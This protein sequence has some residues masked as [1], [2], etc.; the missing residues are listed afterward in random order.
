MFARVHKKSRTGACELDV[1]NVDEL[2]PLPPVTKLCGI[3]QHLDPVT[4]QCVDNVIDN[5]CPAGQHRDA[6]GKCVLDECP[7]GQER[8]PNTLQCVTVTGH[9]SDLGPGYYKDPVTGKCVRD[10]CPTGQERD[11]VTDLC[12]LKK[13]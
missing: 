4:N 12:V 1:L 9:C 8:D 2:P 3:N 5:S 13:V 11:P 10:E 6:S 7:V